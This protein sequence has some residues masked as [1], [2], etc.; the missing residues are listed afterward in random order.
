MGYT[1]TENGSAY[2]RGVAAGEIAARLA[3]HDQ[4]FGAIN[5]SLGRMA[6]EMHEM[7]LA[8]QRL[9]DS[10]AADRATVVTTAVA[11]KD[12]EEARRDATDTRWA[13]LQ[14]WGVA[15]SILFGAGGIIALILSYIH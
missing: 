4:H 6:D 15:A 10:A 14:R 13:P 2:D 7:R 8:L 3:G 9:G 5:G 12:A 1:V 11:L